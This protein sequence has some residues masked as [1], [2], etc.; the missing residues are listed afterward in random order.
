[1]ACG[2]LAICLTI[3]PEGARGK[4]AMPSYDK[5]LMK[6]L[7]Y[8]GAASLLS[9]WLRGRGTM[10]MLHHVLPQSGNAEALRPMLAL[11]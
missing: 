10:F 3:K 2:L 4:L 9:P 1:M 7:H 8:S 5:M 11:K 6:L